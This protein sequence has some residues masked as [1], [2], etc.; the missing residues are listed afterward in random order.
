MYKHRHYVPVIRWKRGEQKA[1][2]ELTSEIRREITPLLEIVP[3]QLEGGK[4]I[5]EAAKQIARYWGW[6]EL[7]LVDFHLLPNAENVI[8]RFSKEAARCNMRFALSTGLRQ[9]SAYRKSVGDSI[10]RPSLFQKSLTTKC[11]STSGLFRGARA[12]DRRTPPRGPA[13]ANFTPHQSGII[14]MAIPACR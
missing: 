3:K 10:P 9:S 2:L 11:F 1:L 5:E 6:K 7:A 8:R 14:L 12:S 4:R 13:Y